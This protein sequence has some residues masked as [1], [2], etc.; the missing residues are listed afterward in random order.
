MKL[1]FFSMLAVILI[2]L[3]LTNLIS[4]PWWLVLLLIY[5]GVVVVTLII[6]IVII[7]KSSILFTRFSRTNTPNKQRTITYED[8]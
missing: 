3:K 2:T 6:M 4:W 5:G 8:K 7:L 1:W